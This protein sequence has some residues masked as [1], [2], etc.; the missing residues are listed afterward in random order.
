MAA[1]LSPLSLSAAP[2]VAG[3]ERF[4]R[5]A[6][7][8]IDRIE[9]GLLLLGELGCV[10]CHRPGDR[11][12]QVSGKA[13]P[14]L[15][16]VGERIDPAWIATYL[17]DPAAAHPGTT[18]PQVLA[19]LDEGARALTSQA[20]AHY[21]A[22]TG[23]FSRGAFP[24]AQDAR[25]RD[26]VPIY[27]RVGCRACHGDR[28][29]TAPHL[30]DQRPLGDLAAKW[31]PTALD[32]FLQ[33][34]LHTR[35][36][37]RMPAFP[38]DDGDRRHLVAALLLPESRWGGVAE[39]TV[40][41][42]AKSWNQTFGA[43]PDF[44]ALGKPDRTG[45]LQGFDVEG[46]AGRN[47]G[48][49][50][51]LSGFFHAPAKGR[52]RF[53]LASDDGSRLLVGGATVIDNDGVHPHSW[54]SGDI[55]LDA[56]IH[57][58]GVEF[59]EAA[60]QCTL[61]LDVAPPGAS[62]ESALAFI[63]PTR[64]GKPARTSRPVPP[65]FAVDA[66]LVA[67]GKQ[68]FVT[69]G[70]AHCHRLDGAEAVALKAVDL[71]QLK[72]L[73]GKAGADNEAGCLGQTPAAK[74]S[75]LYGLDDTQREAIGAALAFLA[76]PAAA[77]APARERA[78]SRS[79]TSLNCLA[80]HVRDGKGGA[81]PAVAILDDDGEPILKDPVRD[82]L[83]TGPIPEMGEEGRLPPTLD[84]V[85]DKLRREFLDEVLANGGVDRRATMHTLMPKWHGDVAKPL[86]ARLADD[87]K[88]DIPIPAI[89]GHAEAEIVD[90][91]RDLVGSKGLGCIKCH[92]FAGD[93]GQGLGA[94][95][96]TR[97]PKRLRHEW[98]LA[99][100][101]NPQRFR[102]GTRMPAAWPEGKV[103]YP[104]ILSGDA[105]NQIESVWRYVSLAKP[106][107]P[108]GLGNDPIELI[109]TDKPVIYRN[110]IEGAGPRAI[111]IGF[112]ERVNIAWDA[113]AFRLALAWKGSFIDARRHWSGRGEGFQP[114]MGD[115]VFSPDAGPC[116]AIL[117][118]IDA[119][120]PA[121][122]VRKRGGRF[123]GYALDDKG[124]P[125]FRWS[126]PAEKIAVRETIGGDS[127]GNPLLKRAVTVERNAGALDGL[128]FR[129][130]VADSI[131]AEAD[132]WWRVA[133]FWRVR[134]LGSGVGPATVVTIDGKKEL[135]YSVKPAAQAPVTFQEEL[136]W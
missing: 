135:R 68:A 133:G 5:H 131:E 79:L 62:R 65:P 20:I 106:R 42:E 21:L 45:P 134:V 35:P 55:A 46:F 78:I 11:E 6:D 3:F 119:P 43:L 81:I 57:R 89:A 104:D 15:D 108:V 50:V 61:E 37:S 66:R 2:I 91:G 27:D 77:E 125:T 13:G 130:A 10:N 98:Y 75:P 97:F 31:S 29:S 12:A 19:N 110:F 109:A 105:G 41:F 86:A 100:V 128:V 126:L 32:A 71:P 87:P 56:G 18:M 28:L 14:I 63:T 76:S 47:D 132:G 116:V 111:G 38:L 9:A 136:S 16:R 34:P 7:E 23:E 95:D 115:A 1:G 113:E 72:T 85:G 73:A 8:A 59:F 82:A 39:Q 88:T 103:F 96:M 127:V 58:I 102:P 114:P 94:I 74:G 17:R 64:D 90:K 93:R 129:A 49:C 22:S 121:E 53:D 101:E 118:A 112:P 99:Y 67:E 80:C 60:G 70:C 40:A 84:G 51:Q 25:P 124:R 36:S 54:R 92:A 24:G 4:G 83:F 48:F 122:P 44:A 69:H 117:P 123:G 30:P 120:W 107:P 26:G 33:N 52:Y